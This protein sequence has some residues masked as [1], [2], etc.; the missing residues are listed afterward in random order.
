LT[1]DLTT[2]SDNKWR[3]ETASA[4]RPASKSEGIKSLLHLQCFSL[5]KRNNQQRQAEILRQLTVVCTCLCVFLSVF[6]VRCSNSSVDNQC[7]Q[8]L[9]NH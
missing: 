9:I 7:I 1:I 2:R 4:E 6:K 8:F 5:I 3:E